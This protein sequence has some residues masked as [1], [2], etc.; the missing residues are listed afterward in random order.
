MTTALQAPPTASADIFVKCSIPTLDEFRA[1]EAMDLNPWYRELSTEIGP[2][3]IYRGA[4]V[5]MLGSNNYLGLTTDPRVKKAAIDAVEQL[6]DRR[7]R[8]PAPQRHAALA[9]RAGRAPGRLGWHGAGAGV[10]DRLHR[11]PRAHFD[12][13]SSRAMPFFA[14]RRPMPLSLTAHAWPTGRSAPSA[15]TGPTACATA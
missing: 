5:V 4:E 2:T 9:H 10:H 1:A 15:T 3:I 11:Q 14:T 13:S 8:E 6:R 7:D 12:A